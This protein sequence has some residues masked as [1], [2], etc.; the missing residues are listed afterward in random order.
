MRG[1]F[2]DDRTVTAGDLDLEA[3]RATLPDWHFAGMTGTSQVEEYIRAAGV[4]I[5]NKV[6]LDRS[7]LAGA[8]RLRLVCIAATGANN[9]DL[10]AAAEHGIT[11]CNVRGYATAS[12][13]EHVFMVMLALG[14]RL[15]EHREAIERGDWGRSPAFS[16][17]DYPFTE[18]AG[19][20]LGIVGYGELGKGV[21]SVARAFG[22]HVL[23]AQR[24]GGPA[25]SGRI[26][27]QRLLAESDVVSLHCPLTPATH[28]LIGT[29]ELKNMRNNAFLI[30]TARGGIVNEAALAA[31]LRNGDIAGAAVDVLSEEPPRPGNPLLEPEIP[32]LIITPHTAWAG[33]RSRQALI[34]ELT[35]NI[36]AF[37]DGSP[38]NMVLP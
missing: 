2:L 31:A 14:H 20:T 27:L 36:R 9:I 17:L 5:T 21:A 10:Q 25:Q 18:L 12:V 30:N 4:V 33:I 11:V 23:L 34:R 28:N 15:H 6:A 26:P 16:L 8:P 1:V 29:P 37:L 35:A 13:V 19:K 22:M 32:N 24:P 38:R 7:L 3:L